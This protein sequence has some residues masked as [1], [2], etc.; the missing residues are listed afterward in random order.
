MARSM[1]CSSLVASLAAIERESQSG[2][3]ADFVRTTRSLYDLLSIVQLRKAIIRKVRFRSPINGRRPA[4]CNMF[5][6]LTIRQ[7]RGQ[8][9]V[10]GCGG[11]ECAFSIIATMK[12]E[13]TARVAR[14]RMEFAR[15]M[16]LGLSSERVDVASGCPTRS[17]SRR[18]S[19]ATRPT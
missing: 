15:A 6:S 9:N 5:D 8:S 12:I 14:R 17:A 11:A 3:L 16:R 4:S 13:L 7:L 10:A 1:K 18:P 19:L 2:G